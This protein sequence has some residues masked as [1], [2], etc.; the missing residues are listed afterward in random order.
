MAPA[1]V[2][3]MSSPAIE[4][5]YRTVT[6]AALVIVLAATLGLIW[7]IGGLFPRAVW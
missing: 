5:T 1:T 3:G 6:T 4:A 7:F 2:S